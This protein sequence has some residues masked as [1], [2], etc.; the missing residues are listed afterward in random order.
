[1][2][3]TNLSYDADLK[4]QVSHVE[5]DGHHH[6]DLHD[7]AAAGHHATDE[8]GN[9]LIEIDEVASRR[10]ARK[11]D[12][13]IVPIVALQYLF[14]FIDRANIGNARLAGL[15]KDLKLLGF[16][17]NILLSMFYVSYIVFEIPANLFTKWLGPGKAI[18]IYT[19]TFGILSIAFAFVQSFGAAC[20]V[21]FLL[22]VAEAGMLPGIS[23]YLSRWYT[24]DELAFRIAMYIVCAPLAGAFGGLLASGILK[25]D[26]IGS[27]HR[28]EQIFLIEG[29]ITTIIG[30]ASYCLMTDRI[31]T[32]K[33]LS[34]EEKDLAVARIKREQVGATVV[35]DKLNTRA[36][37]QG[38]LAPTTLTIGM[39]FLLNNITVQGLAFF[40]PTIVRTIFP[41][42]STVHQQLFTVPPYVVG[43]VF[44]L[45]FPYISMRIKK[46][47]LFLCIA[48]PMVATGFAI[49]LATKNTTARYVSLFFAMSG[50]FIGGP[51]CTSWSAINVASDTSRAAALGWVVMM[52]NIGGLIS[53]W[54]FLPSDAKKGNSLN[55]AS[56]IA[57]F[58]LAF[59]TILFVKA[60][61]KKRERG[62]YDK[63]LEG[64]RPEDAHKLG[65]NHPGFRYKV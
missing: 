34:Q 21:R 32:A 11:I 28:W 53:T 18:P 31:E 25:I 55:L 1:M 10:L 45:V 57:C 19:T 50:A 7:A 41:T 62:D 60:N 5:Y 2:S 54:S 15:E 26:G 48:A 13:Y 36:I 43:A 30:I 23:Y 49:F 12:L 9:P 47:G 14:A 27:V 22:G 61:N 17:Y 44:T 38:I 46:R 56:A 20:A 51:M 3:K 33:W 6:I 8:R 29:I 39:I 16:D 59:G 35:L 42:K 37:K 64:V 40:T 24:K 63:Y 65:N 52:G 4:E 58:L